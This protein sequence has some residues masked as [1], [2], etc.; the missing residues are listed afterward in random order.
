VHDHAPAVRLRGIT[1]A[2]RGVL[3]ND[4]VGLDLRA[5]TVHGLLGENGA[6]KSTLVKILFGLVHPDR[7]TIEVDGVVRRW[8]SP[9][10][11]LAAGIGMVQQHF[12][13]VADFTVAENLVLGDEP[14][15]RGLLDQ[16]RAEREVQ[17]LADRYGFR[18][19]A[20]RQ[21]GRMA[22]GARQRVEILKALYRG[23]QVLILDEPTAA[24]APQ[25]V[26]ELF[27]V[28]DGLRAQGCTIVL[29]THKLPEIVGMCDEV[30]VLRDGAVVAARAI[31]AHEREAG[32]AARTQLEAE[33]ALAMVGRPL[34]EAPARADAAGDAV[35][36]LRAAG[37]GDR[38]GPLDLDVRSGEI[39]GI[40]GVE[41][42]GQTELVELIVGVRRLRTGAMHLDGRDIGRWSV[43]RR[44]GAG[45]AHIAEDRHASAVAVD[46]PL[47][48]NCVLGYHDRP[49][50]TRNGFRL[51]RS[52]MQRFTRE[53]VRRYRVRVPSID[54][55]VGQLSG[56]NQQKLV[57]GRE[58]SRRPRLMVAS[59]PTRGLDVGATAFVHHELADLRG[60]GCAVLLVSLDLAEIMAVADRI[61]VMRDGRV[62][63]EARA[64]DTDAAQLGA[65]MTGASA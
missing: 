3:A 27:G 13:L 17:E 19:D 51:V 43:H 48:D 26:D 42:N 38:L 21:V 24:L 56:G 23:A 63:G 54:A 30:T 36:Q 37:D 44:F 7:G 14:L 31:D 65:W 47:A 39:L 60:A 40:A 59:Q 55:T 34:P 62:A 18:L 49:P 20:G 4:A 2:Y 61:V 16:R 33:L 12:S 46:M 41:G 35:L 5:G 45:L 8:R 57:V 29:I 58:V 11:A 22:V 50:F 1:K 6:G 15:R 53:V 32:S 10:D 25:E 52:E 64:A 9:S 28:I